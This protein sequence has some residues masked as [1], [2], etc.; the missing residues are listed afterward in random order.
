MVFPIL[1]FKYPL[2]PIVST[3]WCRL[4][5]YASRVK[6][7][8]YASRTAPRVKFMPRVTVEAL[9]A[10]NNSMTIHM[11]SLCPNVRNLDWTGL[12]THDDE[13]FQYIRLFLGPKT[14]R[15]ELWVL[16]ADIGR[17]TLLLSLPRDFPGITDIRFQSYDIIQEQL[18]PDAMSDA[19][20][21]WNQL[22]HFH[23]DGR[24]PQRVWTHLALMP[25]LQR[26]GT[27]LFDDWHHSIP[28]PAFRALRHLD[29]FGGHILSCTR[30][31]NLMPP[32][33][34][35][36]TIT[37]CVEA[38][39]RQSGLEH[40]FQTV[41]ASCSYLTLTTLDISLYGEWV[42]QEDI[43]RPLLV[44]SNIITVRIC[45]SP[46]SLGNEMLRDMA[47]AWPHLQSL[48][49]APDQSD[50]R[51]TLAGLIPLLSLPA[52]EDLGIV[53][54]ASVINYLLD[55]PPVGVCNTKITSW[56]LGTSIIQDPYLVAAFL[57]D[58]L[59]NVNI[60]HRRPWGSNGGSLWNQVERSIKTYVKV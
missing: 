21:L 24:L 23:C 42:I 25:T 33:C 43:L 36:H 20:C 55:M 5:T 57:S 39:N 54:D 35:L 15:L 32:Q 3:D 16:G 53:I 22:E 37:I 38:E 30:F 7:L 27:Y 58:V 52:L 60:I 48:Y 41:H 47:M 28:Q 49:L 50:G 17:L 13:N 11:S 51:V 2:R 31:F 9:R 40:F 26:I 29:I 12:F 56:N 19:L 4:R 59:P 45:G 44:F 10:L 8:G 46:I 6:S 1:P 34:R 14:K 18:V